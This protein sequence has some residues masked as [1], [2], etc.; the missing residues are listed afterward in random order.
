MAVRRSWDIGFLVVSVAL[1]VI[2]FAMRRADVGRIRDVPNR[3]RGLTPISE[4]KPI[5]PQ[6]GLRDI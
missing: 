1:V 3:Q 2:G 4:R 6:R 5:G